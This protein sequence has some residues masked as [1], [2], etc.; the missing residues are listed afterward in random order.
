MPEVFNDKPEND[1]IFPGENDSC[2][3]FSVDEKGVAL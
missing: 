1:S 3:I 2:G